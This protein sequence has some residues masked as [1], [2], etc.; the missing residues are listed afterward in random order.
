VWSAGSSGPDPDGRPARRRARRP[1][2]G[3][4]LDDDAG[5]VLDRLRIA[6]IELVERVGEDVGDGQVAEPLPVRRDDVPGRLRGR[7]ARQRLLVGGDVVVPALALL[8]VAEPE[9]PAL[10]RII[11]TRLEPL[12]LFVAI[13]VK[14]E[15]ENGRALF[16]EEALEGV[17][18]VEASGPDPLGDEI[19]DPDDQDVL[20][21]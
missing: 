16:D 9:L 14:E 17:D 3:T 15:F 1:A 8:E 18:L 11:E 13:D 6:R 4:L 21:V 10:V 12:A 2:R 7:A 20:V 19:V 5:E